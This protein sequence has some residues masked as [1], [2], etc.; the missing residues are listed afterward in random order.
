[1]YLLPFS[2]SVSLNSHNLS[3]MFLQCTINCNLLQ[4]F[5]ARD[6][7]PH[8]LGEREVWRGRKRGWERVE[9]SVLQSSCLFANFSHAFLA[10]VCTLCA[11][12]RAQETLH[13]K[14]ASRFFSNTFFW[15]FLHRLFFCYFL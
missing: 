12:R 15:A 1:M 13:T 6:A 10:G 4:I 9:I 3:S 2:S 5:F 8:C 14:N 11:R 7:V